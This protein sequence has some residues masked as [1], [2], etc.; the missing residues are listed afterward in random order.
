MIRHGGVLRSFRNVLHD[1]GAV[2]RGDEDVQVEDDLQ[3]VGEVRRSVYGL[4]TSA[5]K[6]HNVS[7][8]RQDKKLSHLAPTN[9]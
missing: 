1:V 3:V 9:R 7:V 4:Q 8:R 6:T 5:E 2:G